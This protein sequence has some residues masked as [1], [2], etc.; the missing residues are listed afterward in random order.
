M[1]LERGGGHSKLVCSQS[2]HVACQVTGPNMR[3]NQ[4]RNPSVQVV[5]HAIHVRDPSCLH[6]VLLIESVI[7]GGKKVEI[8]HQTEHVDYSPVALLDRKIVR[9]VRLVCQTSPLVILP[10]PETIYAQGHLARIQEIP[11]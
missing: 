1:H 5:L 10:D 11:P 8:V 9:I 7:N 4:C 3:Y 6:G 2:V